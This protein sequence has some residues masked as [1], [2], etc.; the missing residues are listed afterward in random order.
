[1]SATAPADIV[2]GLDEFEAEFRSRRDTGGGAERRRDCQA[3]GRLGI[4]VHLVES[5]SDALVVLGTG[6]FAVPMFQSL[7]DS[8]HEVHALVAAAGPSGESPRQAPANPMRQAAESRGLAVYSPDSINSEEGR[9]LLRELAPELSSFAIMGRFCR[10]KSCRC[11]RWA[12]SI[13]TLRCCRNIAAPH[14]SMGSFQWR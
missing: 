9:Q 13:C 14:R 6:P 10:A 5:Q 8:R 4:A 2:E 1:M 11:R 12:A 7:I 3:V